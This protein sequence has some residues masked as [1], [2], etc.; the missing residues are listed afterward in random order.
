MDKILTAQDIQK[1]GIVRFTANV[2]H[3]RRE[4]R[5]MPKQTADTV[6]SAETNHGR[7][8][9]KC[10]YCPG[11]ELV[12][13]ADPRFYCLSCYNEQAGGQYIKVK[14]PAGRGKIEAELL[15]RPNAENMNWLPSETLKSLQ[16]ENKERGVK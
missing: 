8:I 9:A 10:P 2:L 7:W 13:P 3:A 12:D 5:P 14:F 6:V 11:A 4:S 15:K 1:V 16:G